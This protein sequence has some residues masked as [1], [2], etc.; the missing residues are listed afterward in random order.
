MVFDLIVRYTD[1]FGLQY[2]RDSSVTLIKFLFL[3]F[4]FYKTTIP[5]L[6]NL[7]LIKSTYIIQT[8]K[9]E[10]LEIKNGSLDFN[11]FIW[12]RRRDG[13]TSLKIPELEL[14]KQ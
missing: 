7:F 1:I 14:G 12:N 6:W 2:L 10:K 11:A 4:P 5:Q 8:K 9:E 13:K 3:M